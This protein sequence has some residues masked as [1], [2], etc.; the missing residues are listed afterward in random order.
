VSTSRLDPIGALLPRP[1]RWKAGGGESAAGPVDL[2]VSGPGAAVAVDRLRGGWPS[3]EGAP[4]RVHLQVGGAVG[5]PPRLGVDESHRIEIGADQLRIDAPNE[6]AARR[7]VETVLQ[8]AHTGRLP[9]G[10]IEDA[11]AHP[12][13]GLLVDVCRH[14]IG[15]DRLLATIDA[16]AAVK[17]DVLHL[18]LSDDQA[19]R[20]ESRRYPRLHEVGSDGRWYGRDDVARVVEHAAAAGIRVVPEIDVPGHT[21]SWLV[22][23]PELAATPGPFELRRA[24]GI[25]EVALHP[26]D[27]RVREV[28]A[29][30]L[31][32][33]VELFPDQ[34]VHIGGDEVAPEGW[35]GVDVA[36][37]QAQFT[38]AV[39]SMVLERG[40]TPV[41]WD[42]AW[43][44][45][46]PEGV[47]TQV[48]RGHRRLRH[49]AHAG[50]PVLYS[51]PYYLDL[52]F[53]PR[54][55]RLQPLAGA[56]DAAA[57]RAAIVEDPRLGEWAELVRLGD[58]LWD[59]TVP[60]DPPDGVDEAAVLGGEACH[61]TELSPEEL[62]DLRTWP[63]AAA[64]AEVL[65]SGPVADDADL[66]DRLD[67]VSMFLAATTDVDPDGDRRA[68]WLRLAAGDPVVADAIA[69]LA[70]CCEPVKWYARHAALPDGRIDGAFDRLADVLEPTARDA[71]RLES[72]EDPAPMVA[73]WRRA[74]DRVLDAPALPGSPLA[75]VQEIAARLLDLC[76]GE[77]PE[78]P[79]VVGDVLLSVAIALHDR[80]WRP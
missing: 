36:E 1:R 67:A 16:M 57:A 62:F 34:Y 48:W 53:D 31:D 10:V 72:G 8:L 26:T 54:H 17:L 40:R 74:V 68:A 38:D 49:V 78:R 44:P 28:V 63:A 41:L 47:V 64:V 65:W 52:G 33:L 76:D 37:A 60:E 79:P 73:A 55:L 13:R 4:T 70:R 30:L 39:V 7:A 71:V 58:A 50:G 25:A 22:A 59:A 77:V 23:H 18:H 75:E 2:S 32:E 61:W 29:G 46:L 3:A 21:T 9:H 80:G 35:P 45:D 19:F 12:W 24:A 42:D 14:W 15:P 43:H 6:V 11:P 69:V 51:A 5:G 27:A 56:G 20:L 66:H